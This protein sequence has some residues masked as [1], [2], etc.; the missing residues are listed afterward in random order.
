METGGLYQYILTQNQVIENY[1]KALSLFTAY[2][3]EAAKP[4]LNRLIE[5]NAPEAIK[6]K[7]RLLISYMEVPGFDTFNRRDNP[8]YADVI[9]EPVL[10]RD[11]HV[12]WRGMAANVETLPDRTSF[13]FL[14][15]YDTRRVM[16]GSVQVEFNQALA[17][18]SEKPLEVLGRI[19]PVSTEKGLDISL[20]GVAIHQTGILEQK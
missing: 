16:E 11:V 4:E 13:K 17:I 14:V 9:K 1:E 7:C 8:G 15:G 20:E 5:S 6:N 2:R 19:V 10:Y 12:I 18:N 3:D